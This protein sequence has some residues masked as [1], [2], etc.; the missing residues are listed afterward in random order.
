M[1]DFESRIKVHRLKPKTLPRFLFFTMSSE[2][3]EST[4]SIDIQLTPTDQS[5]S[6]QDPYF[7]YHQLK[8]IENVSSPCSCHKFDRLN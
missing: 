4:S 1:Y 6:D 7:K 5:Y 3:P 8:S 2:N